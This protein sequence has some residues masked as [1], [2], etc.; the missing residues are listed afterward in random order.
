MLRKVWRVVTLVPLL[1]RVREVVG[2]RGNEGVVKVGVQE[3]EE[4]EAVE[5]VAVD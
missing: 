5:G 2:R 4:V 1:P 3:P